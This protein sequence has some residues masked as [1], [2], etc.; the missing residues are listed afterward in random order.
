MP[1]AAQ[2]VSKNN[3]EAFVWRE[4]CQGWTLVDAPNLHVIQERMPSKTFE[5]RHMHEHTRQLYFILEGEATVVIN[6][7]TLTLTVGEGVDIPAGI[8][9]QMRNDSAAD[10]E[11]LVI[12]TQRPRED[13]TDL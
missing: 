9:H 6:G 3:R 1:G 11:F 12:S 4:V 7:D 5:L 10:L 2:P 8:P 13:R